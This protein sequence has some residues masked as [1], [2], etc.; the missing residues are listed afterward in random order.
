MLAKCQAQEQSALSPFFFRARFRGPASRSAHSTS[1]IG[2]AR[3]RSLSLLRLWVLCSLAR[4][5]PS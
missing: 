3:A 2:C 5:L 1:L 4:A